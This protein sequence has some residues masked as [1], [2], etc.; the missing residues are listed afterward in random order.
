MKINDKVIYTAVFLTPESQKRLLELFS[1]K[2]TKVFAHHST[3]EFRPTN[4]DIS[5]GEKCFLKITG[6]VCDDR[7]EAVLVENIFSQKKHPHITLSVREDTTPVYID[8]MIEQ[9]TIQPVDQ[10]ILLEGAVGYFNGVRDVVNLG[11]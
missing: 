4:P 5:L 1:P 2:F 3:I 9:V 6:Y 7:A 11:I 8:K 10:E